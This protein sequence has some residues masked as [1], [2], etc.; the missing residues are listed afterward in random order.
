MEAACQR[1]FIKSARPRRDQGRADTSKVSCVGAAD[2][3][4]Y[5]FLR[6]PW[7][8]RGLA[9]TESKKVYRT[10]KQ[11][12]CHPLSPAMYKTIFAQFSAASASNSL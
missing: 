9:P 11:G 5:A 1:F 8:A 2:I 12:I 6:S 4:F 3:I 10:K 7:L